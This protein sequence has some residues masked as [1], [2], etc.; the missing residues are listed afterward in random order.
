MKTANEEVFAPRGLRCVVL[1]TA[2]MMEVV[3][4]GS[5]S[6]VL[7]LPGLDVRGVRGV[8]DDWGG[9]GGEDP[10]MRR[11][12]ALGDLVARLT[13]EGLPP[14][15]DYENWWKRMGS[16]QAQKKDAK[17]NRKMAE[18]RGKGLEK[19]EKNM[20]KAQRKAGK[21]DREI[22][23]VERVRTKEVARAERALSGKKGRD[24]K[25][26]AKI[27]KDL[28]RELRKLDKEQSKVLT[29][30]EE[31]MGKEMRK[32]ESE[33]KKADGKEHK[34]AQKIYWIVIDKA[35]RLEQEVG[36]ADDVEDAESQKST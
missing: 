18:A 27:E 13:F 9:E 25:E 6:G 26:R 21:Y 36:V 15:E 32:G 22:G 17:M 29:E 31:E 12:R 34:V 20:E 1:K 33:I 16:N 4:S 3:G 19:Y 23:K 28:Q 35:D 11:M 5:G 14:P 2:K 7:R 24:P 10:R 8:R 30:K